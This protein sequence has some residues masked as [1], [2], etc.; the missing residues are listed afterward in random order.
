MSL[1]G[2]WRAYRLY[3]GITAIRANTDYT[4]QEIHALVFF[5]FGQFLYDLPYVP[6]FILSLVG[7]WRLP[8][9]YA[10]FKKVRFSLQLNQLPLTGPPVPI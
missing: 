3:K 1:L 8:H 10:K 6:L 4:A 9:L 5:E 2:P 7:I